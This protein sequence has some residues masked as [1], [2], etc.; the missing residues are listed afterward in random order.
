MPGLVV[1]QRFQHREIGPFPRRSLAVG[2]RI[3]RAVSR[4]ARSSEASKSTT[5]RPMMAH[6]AWTKRAGLHLL[7]ERCDRFALKPEIHR[8]NRA[9]ELRPHGRARIRRRQATEKRDIGGEFQDAAV[10][11]SFS[12]GRSGK[13]LGR[14]TYSRDHD[15][16]R[17]ALTPR[18][19]RVF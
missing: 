13:E 4:I 15:V 2:F 5:W 1:P 7:R 12:M 3:C 19:R 8:H 11:V 6:E 9:A 10:V 16:A 14:C 18:P 17:P